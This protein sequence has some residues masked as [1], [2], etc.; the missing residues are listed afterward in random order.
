MEGLFLLGLNFITLRVSISIVIVSPRHLVGTIL[1][2]HQ[3]TQKLLWAMK[4]YPGQLELQPEIFAEHP[5][6]W[7]RNVLLNHLLQ[8]RKGLKMFS[9]CLTNHVL[10]PWGYFMNHMPPL[11]FGIIKNLGSVSKIYQLYLSLLLFSLFYFF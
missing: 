5:L 7:N 3:N 4:Y 1:I 8:L 2:V 11:L 9:M 6:A 10:G